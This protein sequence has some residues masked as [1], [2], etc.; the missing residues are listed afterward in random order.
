MNSKQLQLTV[1]ILNVISLGPVL[2]T[3]DEMTTA[4]KHVTTKYTGKKNSG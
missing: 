4:S 1:I 3:P 2:T